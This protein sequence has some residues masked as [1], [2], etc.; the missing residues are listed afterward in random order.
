MLK[1][2]RVFQAFLLLPLAAAL[3]SAQQGSSVLE[4]LRGSAPAAVQSAPAFDAA[5]AQARAQAAADGIPSGKD[6]L[7][8]LHELT[9]KGF[10]Q[11]T[12]GEAQDYIFSAAD[13]IRED[14]VRGVKDAYS[15]VFVPGTSTEGSAYRENGDLNEDGFTDKGGMNVEHVWPQSF[16]DKQLP[17]KSDVHHL[18]ATFIHPNSVRG[19]NPFCLVS[20]SGRYQNSGGAKASENC[21]EPPDEAKGRVSRSLLYFM[22]R[23]YDKPITKGG[24]GEHF[25]NQKLELLLRWNREFPPSREEQARNDLVQSFQGNRNPY[26]DDPSLA[27]KIGFEAFKRHARPDPF[28]LPQ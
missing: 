25:W 1:R 11:H 12:Y 23:Y 21:F 22:T 2:M 9:G 20:G 4:A 19:S 26:V 7:L 10:R 14:G 8:A 24:F 15:G 27:D 6:L 17:M 13:N 3:C 18:M 28:A 16:F 5:P